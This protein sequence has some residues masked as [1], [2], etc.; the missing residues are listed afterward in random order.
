[1]EEVFRMYAMSDGEANGTPAEFES[2]HDDF[3]EVSRE[4]AQ[5]LRH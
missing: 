5:R 3:E 1:M 4:S 2:E